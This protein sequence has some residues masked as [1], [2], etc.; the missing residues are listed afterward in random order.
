MIAVGEP[1]TYQAL[2]SFQG[3]WPRD[4]DLPT[5]GEGLGVL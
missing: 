1:A 5:L 4:L 2:N 3:S